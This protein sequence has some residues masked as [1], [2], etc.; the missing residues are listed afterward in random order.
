MNKG[1]FSATHFPTVHLCKIVEIKQ[2]TTVLFLF[3]Y[4]LLLRSRLLSNTVHSQLKTTAWL[5]PERHG[6]TSVVIKMDHMS[7]Q[8]TVTDYLEVFGTFWP[9][10]NVGLKG[11]DLPRKQKE[12]PKW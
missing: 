5:L 11:C 2:D 1:F 12:S 6:S 4:S 8:H 10:G 7:V 9:M 3:E